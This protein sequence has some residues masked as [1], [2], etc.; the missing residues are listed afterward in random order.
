[1][2]K[3][4]HC[5]F[6]SHWVSHCRANRPARKAQTA[7]SRLGSNAEVHDAVPLTRSAWMG[8]R[9]SRG[10][11]GGVSTTANAKLKVSAR[12]LATPASIPVE[13]VAPEREKPR[14]GR[15]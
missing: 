1:M 9:T 5:P 15:H 12:D 4:Y 8:R 11:I 10:K 13:M 14:N 6:S 7:P 2:P 3:R